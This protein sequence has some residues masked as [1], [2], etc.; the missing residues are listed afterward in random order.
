VTETAE[1][2]V[3]RLVGRNIKIARQ[4]AGMSGPQLAKLCGVTPSHVSHWEAGRHEPRRHNRERIADVLDVSI[5]WLY[6]DHTTDDEPA[7]AA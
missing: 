5:G 3:A 2:N 4:L 6:T 1:D 7:A